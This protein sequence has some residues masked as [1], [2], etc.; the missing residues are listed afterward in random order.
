MFLGFYV[1]CEMPKQSIY[2]YYPMR[3]LFG[4]FKYCRALGFVERLLVFCN[5]LYY[6]KYGKSSLVPHEKSVEFPWLSLCKVKKL[7]IYVHL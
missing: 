5:I 4:F 7:V 2:I 6:S 1:L 3:Y